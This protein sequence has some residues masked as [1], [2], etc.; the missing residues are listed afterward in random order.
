MTYSVILLGATGYLGGDILTTLEQAN[1]YD[2]TCVVRPE[3]EACLTGRKANILVV[4][5]IVSPEPKHFHRN[6]EYQ[7]LATIG[8][9]EDLCG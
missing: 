6:Y 1:N 3:R 5:R 8:I 7:P 2:I 4:R 9:V